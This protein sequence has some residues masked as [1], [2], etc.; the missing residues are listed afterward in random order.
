MLTKPLTPGEPFAFGFE[1]KLRIFSFAAVC[2]LLTLRLDGWKAG[3]LDTLIQIG[4]I[5]YS[6]LF[7]FCVAVFLWP[8]WLK[9]RLERRLPLFSAWIESWNMTRL[10]VGVGF[11]FE[12]I[13]FGLLILQT[14]IFERFGYNLNLLLAG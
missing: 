14:R 4:L 6:L 10:V 13:T 12:V 9:T 5:P 11:G 3:N 1:D 8:G 7:I 2:L